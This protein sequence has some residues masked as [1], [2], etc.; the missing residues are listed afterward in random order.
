[1][2]FDKWTPN[3]EVALWGDGKATA[4]KKECPLTQPPGA[5]YQGDCDNCQK[6]MGVRF[7]EGTEKV[8]WGN[9]F[10]ACCWAKIEK[11]QP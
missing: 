3:I 10:K 2:D 8:M 6:F 11:D 4:D 7:P 5:Q 1:M 9:R